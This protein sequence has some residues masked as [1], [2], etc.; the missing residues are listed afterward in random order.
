MILEPGDSVKRESHE[1]SSQFLRVEEGELTI[2]FYDGPTVVQRM[3]LTESGNDFVIIQ[4]RIYHQLENNSSLPVL[5]Y[6]IYSPPAH[7]LQEQEA[8]ERLSRFSIEKK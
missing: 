6:T 2:V 1:K 3:L 5:F 4:P 8:D 7:T